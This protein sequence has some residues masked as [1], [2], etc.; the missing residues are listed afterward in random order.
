LE[1]STAF[2]TP[3]DV[4]QKASAN[5]ELAWR[6]DEAFVQRA[7]ELGKRMEALGVIDRQ[8]DFDQL[9]DLTF[10]RKIEKEWSSPR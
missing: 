5:M 9:F 10:V 6:M 4:L 2:G 1:K 3:L 7:R 8:P